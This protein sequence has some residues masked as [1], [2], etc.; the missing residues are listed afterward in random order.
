MSLTDQQH[1][2]QLRVRDAEAAL[3]RIIGTIERRS[4]RVRRFSATPNAHGDWDVQVSVSG[5]RPIHTLQGQLEKLYDCISLAP[6]DSA[7]A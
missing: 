7:H 6:S 1:H 5:S 2:L 3:L 4:F